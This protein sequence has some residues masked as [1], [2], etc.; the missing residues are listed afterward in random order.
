MVLGVNGWIWIGPNNPQFHNLEGPDMV[1][2]S[3]PTAPPSDTTTPPQPPTPEQLQAVAYAASAVAVLR[4]L[5]FPIYP[6]TIVTVVTIARAQGVVPREMLG[7][8]FLALVVDAEVQRR[9]A[10]EE[11]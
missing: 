10:M 9:R 7:S 11:H 8:D 5:Y 3:E 1:A 6:A 2:P 4:T